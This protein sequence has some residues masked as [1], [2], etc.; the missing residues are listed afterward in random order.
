MRRSV[1]DAVGIVTWVGNEVMVSG[2]HSLLLRGYPHA[3]APIGVKCWS[4]VPA[5]I[6]IW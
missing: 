5:I 6:C 2:A 4:Y 3:I 1:E